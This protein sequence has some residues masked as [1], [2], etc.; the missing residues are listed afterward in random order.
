MQTVLISILTAISNQTTCHLL[1]FLCFEGYFEKEISS[2]EPNQHF[3]QGWGKW[4]VDGG[5]KARLTITSKTGNSLQRKKPQR[6][7]WKLPSD[8]SF[9]HS[10][11]LAQ[12][13]PSTRWQVPEVCHAC[14]KALPVLKQGGVV[15][16]SLL[17]LF[18]F[19]CSELNKVKF[20]C[21]HT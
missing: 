8:Y 18:G 13:I 1:L 5:E 11:P 14:Q 6:Q 4:K 3:P 15:E 20:S 17:P 16:A 10:S 19:L 9:S 2:V 12:K 21:Y 7:G